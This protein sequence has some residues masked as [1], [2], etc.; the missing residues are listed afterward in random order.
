MNRIAQTAR[1]LLF[2]LFAATFALSPG[3]CRKEAA[4]EAPKAVDAVDALTLPKATSAAQKA[5]MVAMLAKADAYDGKTDKVVSKCAMCALRMDGQEKHEF[6]IEGYKMHFCG[7]G[8]L[9]RCKKDP[10]KTLLALVVPEK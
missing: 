3:G 2:A 8:C 7:E 6:A 4:P 9:E 5:E 10:A 1:P